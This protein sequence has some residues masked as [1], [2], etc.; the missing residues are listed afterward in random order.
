MNLDIVEFRPCI[1]SLA[2]PPLVGKT[3][4]GNEL[5]RRTNIRFIEVDAQRTLY[6]TDPEETLNGDFKDP[7]LRFTAILEA[8]QTSY[9]LATRW[10]RDGEPV[11]F[12]GTYSHRSYV[13]PL[14]EYADYY[15][16]LNKLTESALRIFV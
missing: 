10:L 9:H 12:A 13:N 8:Y 7:L 4:L 5:A 1:L 6:P 14:R 2:G 15:G 16:R 11:M 3:T